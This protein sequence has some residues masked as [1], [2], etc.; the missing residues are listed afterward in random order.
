MPEEKPKPE[1]PLVNIFVNVLI[2]VMVLSYL[3][4]DPEIQMKLGK[5]VKPWHI[6]P[7]WAMII[8]LGLSLPWRAWLGLGAVRIGR[9]I[10][11]E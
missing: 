5:P 11:A 7:L 2:P 8:A 10:G 4:K 6:G 1:H 3:S 9:R